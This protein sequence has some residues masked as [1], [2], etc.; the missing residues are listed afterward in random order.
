[1]QHSLIPSARRSPHYGA[2]LAILLLLLVVSPIVPPSFGYGVELAFDLV[3]VIGVYSVAWTSRHRWPFLVLTVVTLAFRWTDLAVGHDGFSVPATALAV[4]WLSYAVGLILVNLARMERVD[5]NTILAAIVSYLLVAVGFAAVFEII[6]TLQPG[7]FSG[8]PE[9]VS[10]AAVAHAL[11]YYSVV[12]ITT[13]GYG[14]ILPVSPLAR[15]VV[16]LEGVF[17]TLY[18]AVMIARLVGLH[19]TRTAGD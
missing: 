17:G 18:L 13:M 2:L 16:S 14:D 10:H 9:G 19:S 5:T 7:S 8:L 11:L 6:E 4:V 1:M 15:S 12:S 3:L